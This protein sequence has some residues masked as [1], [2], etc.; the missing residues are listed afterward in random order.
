L[1]NT[2]SGD[3]ILAF[4]RFCRGVGWAFLGLSRVLSR[5]NSGSFV[6]SVTALAAT[7][8]TKLGNAFCAHLSRF[9]MSEFGQQLCEFSKS[10]AAADACF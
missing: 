8:W 6:V 5:Q 4:C 1:A 2:I 7:K 3:K 9:A 10:D